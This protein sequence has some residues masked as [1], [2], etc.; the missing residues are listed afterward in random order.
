MVHGEHSHAYFQIHELHDVSQ[1][2]YERESR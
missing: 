1:I 2:L